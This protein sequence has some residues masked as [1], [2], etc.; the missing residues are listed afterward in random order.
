MNATEIAAKLTDVH[1]LLA[2]S[3]E[4]DLAKQVKRGIEVEIAA[5]NAMA[6][7]LNIVNHDSDCARCHGTVRVYNEEQRQAVLAIRDGL[8]QDRMNVGATVTIRGVGM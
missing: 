1:P 7:V 2:D 6:H 8:R 4:M 5:D 3:F